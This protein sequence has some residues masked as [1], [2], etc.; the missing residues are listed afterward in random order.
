MLTGRAVEKKLV[1]VGDAARA[2]GDYIKSGPS[3]I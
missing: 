1:F 3:F 2:G